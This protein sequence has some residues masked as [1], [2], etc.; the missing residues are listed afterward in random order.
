M[1]TPISAL[2]P[3]ASGLAIF[4]AGAALLGEYRRLFWRDPRAVMSTEI[5]TVLAARGGV[6][7]T[8]IVALVAGLIIASVG[9]ILFVLTLMY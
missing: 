3:V 6:G 1:E 8:A 7:Y 9:C 5:V 2:A 4:F